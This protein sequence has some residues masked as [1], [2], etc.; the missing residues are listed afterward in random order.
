MTAA[1]IS[2]EEYMRSAYEHDAEYV[3]GRIVERPMPTPPHSR[4]QAYLIRILYILAHPLGYEALPELRIRT[5]QN[6]TRIPDLCLTRDL[7]ETLLPSTPP[8]LCVEILSP[9]ERMVEVL[10]KVSEYLEFGVE[11]IWVVD[12]E[13]CTGEIFTQ[14]TTYRVTDGVFR[15]GSIEVNVRLFRG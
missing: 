11:C 6:R 3:D 13:S 12:P 1:T 9:D 14:E 7:G 5:G 8:Y 4:M 15:A 2:L 10:A